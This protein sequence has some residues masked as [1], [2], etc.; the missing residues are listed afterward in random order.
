M[1]ELVIFAKLLGLLEQVERTIDVF[2]FE[3]VHGEN[4]ANLAKLLA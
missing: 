4:V 3:V 1:A 2:L